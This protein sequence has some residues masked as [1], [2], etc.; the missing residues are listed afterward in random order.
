M[1]DT[2]SALALPDTADIF[3]SSSVYSYLGPI[4]DNILKSANSNYCKFSYPLNGDSPV[5]IDKLVLKSSVLMGFQ[6]Q[7]I[8]NGYNQQETNPQS[9]DDF[10]ISVQD[11]TF[12]FNPAGRPLGDIAPDTVIFENTVQTVSNSEELLQAANLQSQNTLLG[13]QLDIPNNLL[14]IGN[15]YTLR[16]R[17]LLTCPDVVTNFG[18][19][20]YLY[21]ESRPFY[22][23]WSSTIFNINQ[24]PSAG[25]LCVNGQVNPTKIPLG[26]MTLS[27]SIVDPDGPKFGYDV[28]VSSVVPPTTFQANIWDTN[29]VMDSDGSGTRLYSIPYGGPLLTRGKTYYW[30]VRANDGLVDGSWSTINSFKINSKPRVSSLKVNG[31]EL[32]TSSV[33][34]VSNLAPVITWVFDDSDGDLQK[35]YTLSY[36]YPNGETIT[37][38]EVGQG[39]TVI[40][41]SFPTNKEITINLVVKD[42][43]EQSDVAIGKFLTNA[44]PKISNLLIDGEEDPVDLTNLTPTISWS[45]QD[46]DQGDTQQKYRVKIATDVDFSNVIWDTGE[47]ASASTSVVYPGAP[48]LTHSQGTYYVRVLVFEGV[49]WSVEDAS[50]FAFFAINHIPT[51]PVLTYPTTG[52]YSGTVNVQWT[53]STDADSDPLTYTLETTSSRLSNKGW[54]YLA[55][56][57]PQSQTNYLL[58]LSE[59]PSGDNYG[60]RISASD[61]MSESDYS[62]S[63][64]FSIL[65]HEPNSPTPVF[66]EGADEVRNILRVA[67]IE[68]NPTDVDGDSVFYVIELSGNASDSNPTWTIL[69]NY[70]EGTTGSLFDVSGLPDGSDYKVKLR[71]IDEHGS[72]GTPVYSGIFEISNQVSATDFERNNGI[73]FISTSDGK[74][75][76]SKENIWQFYEDWSDD[77]KGPPMEIYMTEGATLTKENGELKI[78]SK[79]STC[80]LRHKKIEDKS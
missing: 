6:I 68:A 34:F 39:S 56:P 7:I 75:F 65:N 60:L 64:R 61:G 42:D 13:T 11:Q 32:L 17:T 47:V 62:T 41:P 10:T 18:N 76:E 51:V 63:E 5:G 15:K 22:T 43:A 24:P 1:T 59:I 40:L 44:N 46:I 37:I 77:P 70:P 74:V 28:Q 38:T 69:G 26:P 53:A 25:N 52:A 14:V 67:W 55:G 23:G 48:V 27:F 2:E 35:G 3:S 58:D 19:Q 21:E 4:R 71:V 20:W 9:L 72:E 73:L 33:P 50:N 29:L 30:R 80:I 31:T 45:F 12:V 79:N 54:E 57:F 78:T 16:V 49:S 66:P 8:K 36:S